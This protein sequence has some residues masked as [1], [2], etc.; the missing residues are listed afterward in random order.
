MATISLAADS[1][2]ITLNGFIITDLVDGDTVTITPVN[3]A[4]A[5]TRS[6]RSVNIQ[7]RSDAR[8]RDVV[9]RVP[10]YGDSDAWLNERMQRTA[11][12]ILEGTIKE[13][14]VRDGEEVVSTWSVL[15]GSVTDQPTD[16]RN[17]VDGSNMME[18]TIR[19]NDCTRA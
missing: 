9:F 13:D 7:A 10:K 11:P 3:P 12:E 1:T 5:H 14:L 15:Q 18:Y 16:T 17:N 19:F 4:T 2:T 6:V 8:V